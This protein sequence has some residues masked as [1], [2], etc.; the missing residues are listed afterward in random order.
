MLLEVEVSVTSLAVASEVMRRIVVASRRVMKTIFLE[1]IWLSFF[2]DS[3]R[4]L[5]VEWNLSTILM[6]HLQAYKDQVDVRMIPD[7]YCYNLDI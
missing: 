7:Q 6:S 1:S 4:S 3:S 2:K 5:K